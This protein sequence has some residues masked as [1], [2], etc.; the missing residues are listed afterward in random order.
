MKIPGGEKRPGNGIEKGAMWEPDQKV[1]LVGFYL[2]VYI[3]PGNRSYL[4]L[5]GIPLFS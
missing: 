5:L 4:H 2:L 1:T 3:K